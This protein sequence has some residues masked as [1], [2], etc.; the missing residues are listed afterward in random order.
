MSQPPPTYEVR[1]DKGGKLK[2]LLV[3]D[4]RATPHVAKISPVKTQ[5]PSSTVSQPSP[6][7]QPTRQ[8][9]DKTFSSMH[10]SSTNRGIRGPLALSPSSLTQAANDAMALVNL[11]KAKSNSIVHGRKTEGERVKDGKIIKLKHKKTV[12]VVPQGATPHAAGVAQSQFHSNANTTK[13][14]SEVLKP[15]PKKAVSS[16]KQSLLPLSRIRTIMRTNVQST[17]STHNVSQDSVALVTK[18]TELFIGQ[19]AKD[20]HKVA[21]ATAARDVKYNHLAM[22]VRKVKR[23]NFLHDVLPEKVI[24]S[25][26]LSSLRKQPSD[27]T[28]ND[29][30][31]SST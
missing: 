4:P 2:L 13:S 10:H 19:L 12:T 9:S 1:P 17:N 25:H 14:H 15:I 31:K 8:S 27:H 26:Y 23:T 22:T 24:G 11:V 3:R 16:P 7:N 30:S 20:S 21:V 29:H 5:P 28:H 18:A 6:T